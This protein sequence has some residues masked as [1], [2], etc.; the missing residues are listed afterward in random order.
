M[1]TG[2]LLRRDRWPAR[3]M[4]KRLSEQAPHF[5]I[6]ARS[7][8]EIIRPE[9]DDVGLGAAGRS[10]KHAHQECHCPEPDELPKAN[11]N[12]ANR[13]QE[14]SPQQSTK[15][16]LVDHR[17][18]PQGKPGEEP[19][20]E[21]R[22]EDRGRSTTPAEI[23]P[24]Q[25]GYANAD[26]RRGRLRRQTRFE[27]EEHP[28]H[29]RCPQHHWRG[30]VALR[31]LSDLEHDATHGLNLANAPSPGPDRAGTMRA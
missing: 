16:A 8:L 15:D 2:Q 31:T 24:K 4:K 26:P 23:D 29:H 17:G 27:Q 5:L 9:D 30:D 14:E 25:G 1:G 10:T 21:R 22:H 7:H 28:R 19:A 20:H 12:P 3:T 6:P 11:G 13:D 18:D